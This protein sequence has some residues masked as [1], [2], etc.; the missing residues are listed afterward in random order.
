MAA[1]SVRISL[2]AVELRKR[3]ESTFPLVGL[4]GAHAR[5]SSGDHQLLDLLSSFKYVEGLIWTYP[6]LTDAV[7]CAR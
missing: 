7:R 2:F 1:S 3:L 4:L 6:L 5:D